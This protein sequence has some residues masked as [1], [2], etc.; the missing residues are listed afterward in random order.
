M[1]QQQ[2]AGKKNLSTSG[3]KYER[4]LQLCQRMAEGG[5]SFEANRGVEASAT[6]RHRASWPGFW[7]YPRAALMLL[8]LFLIA[9][10]A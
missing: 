3:N 8:C 7:D 6:A 2:R 4:A 1:P 9:D 10:N 5:P